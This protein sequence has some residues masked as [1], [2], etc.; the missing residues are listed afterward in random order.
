MPTY[1]YQAIVQADVCYMEF[2]TIRI[3]CFVW[4]DKTVHDAATVESAAFIEQEDGTE[5]LLFRQRVREP[6]TGDECDCPRIVRCGSQ[7]AVFLVTWLEG[8]RVSGSPDIMHATLA[9]ILY[10]TVPSWTF[11]GALVT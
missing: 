2:G 4:L 6:A 3:R 8:D 5:V 1:S 9:P 7:G 11:N 10:G